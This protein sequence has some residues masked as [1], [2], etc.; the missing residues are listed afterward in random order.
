MFKVIDP[1]SGSHDILYTVTEIMNHVSGQWP[2][3]KGQEFF[4]CHVHVRENLK[5]LRQ[6]RLL[7]CTMI[8]M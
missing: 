2:S 7:G 1:M 3:P 6:E 8:Q 4:E 5:K